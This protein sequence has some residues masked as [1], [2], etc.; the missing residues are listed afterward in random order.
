MRNRDSEH[1]RLLSIFHYVLGGIVG[2]FSCLPIFHVA[3]GLIMIFS[4]GAFPD[5]NGQ[6][7]PPFIGWFFVALGSAVIVL[8]WS[9]AVC[10]LLSGWFL[11]RRK[12]Y[13][14]CMVIAGLACLYVPFGTVLGVFTFIV[15]GRPSV[16][17]G[18]ERF[19]PVDALPAEYQDE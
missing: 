11:S 18:F 9:L 16:R 15:L 13:I 19:H 4:P 14:F 3:L 1:V 12:H 5:G 2:V 7:P 6:P 10:L 17:A 8:G